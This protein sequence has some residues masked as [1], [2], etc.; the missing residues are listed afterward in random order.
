MGHVEDGF[1]GVFF[2]SGG[3]GQVSAQLWD[4]GEAGE[5]FQFVE[6]DTS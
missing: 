4:V 6:G 1:N 3:L 5:G 2:D